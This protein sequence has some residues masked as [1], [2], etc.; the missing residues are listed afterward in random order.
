MAFV[1]LDCGLLNSTLWLQR[2]QRELFITALLMAEP[3]ELKEPTEQIEVRSLNHTGFFVQPGWY[4]FVP[5]AGIGIIDRARVEKEAGL[6]AL[7]ALGSP[8]PESRSPEHDGRRLIRI[9][10]GYLILNFQKYREKD[11]TTADRSRR[12][13][14]R[15][16]ASRR[17]NVVSRVTSRS[18]TQAEA[19]AEA[20]PKDNKDAKA[21]SKFKKP[22]LHDVQMYCIERR[23]SHSSH[24]DPQKFFDYY[25]SNGWRVG[26]NPMKNWKAAVRTW[27]SNHN[28]THKDTRSRAKRVSDKLDDIAR[29]DIEQ[30]GHTDKLG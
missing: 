21:S 5:A 30:N 4:G 14:E 9:D 12:Y 17:D 3:F 7:E 8:D 13:R 6:V 1:K 29:R 23:E 24:V 25:E 10:G 28:G 27:E 18:A 2:E 11:H 20:E 22:E 16:L 19:E 26:K 15:K